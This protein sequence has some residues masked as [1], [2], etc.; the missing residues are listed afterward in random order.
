MAKGFTE[1]IFL[2]LSDVVAKELKQEQIFQKKSH[3]HIG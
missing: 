1:N 3:T 2:T